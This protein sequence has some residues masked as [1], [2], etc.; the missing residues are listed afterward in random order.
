MYSDIS[1]AL[2]FVLTQTYFIIF[3]AMVIEGTLVTVA[4]ASAASFGIFNIYVIF[5]LSYFG[6]LLGDIIHYFLGRILRIAVVEKYFKKHH[7]AR[8]TVKM[9]SKKIHNNLWESMI[10]TK[11]TPIFSTPGL[12]LMGAS[13]VPFRKYIFWAAVF[14]FPVSLFYTCLG[15]FFGYAVKSVLAIFK[16]SEYA[17]FFVIIGLVAMFFVYR[18]VYRKVGRELAKPKKRIRK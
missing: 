8:S 17:I 13:K 4:A 18:A 1:G 3:I 6:N 9:L 15:Y 16:I 7:A 10:L 2:A 11:I 5:M 12:L 14:V